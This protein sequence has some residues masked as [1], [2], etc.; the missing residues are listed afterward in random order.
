M[1][2]KDILKLVHKARAAFSS[3]LWVL[4]NH[5]IITLSKTEIHPK[6]KAE[7]DPSQIQI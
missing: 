5:T 7:L 2:E 4:G 6:A 1:E 3:K